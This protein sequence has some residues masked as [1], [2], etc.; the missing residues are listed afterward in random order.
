M[1][2]YRCDGIIFDL[3]GVLVDSTTTIERHWWDWATK[4]GIDPA[5]SLH[6]I[7]GLTTAEGIRL[8]APHL[9]AE[10]EADEID[11]AEAKDTEGVVAYEGVEALLEA[12][13]AGWW[14]VATSGTRDTAVAR[15]ITAGLNVPD[16]LISANDVVRGKPEPEPYLLAAERMEVQAEGCV[17]VEDS[18]G[19]IRAGLAAGMRVIGVASTHTPEELEMADT[20]VKTISEIN[21]SVNQSEDTT[22]KMTIISQDQRQ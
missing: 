8:V 19:G 13:P 2:T 1:K 5:E 4:H 12:I 9:D 11:S 14:S 18:S 15:M 6:A 3:D 21:V 22:Y 16:V 7:L 10:A 20:I 17:V